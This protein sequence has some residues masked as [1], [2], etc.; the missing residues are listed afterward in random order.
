MYIYLNFYLF[1]LLKLLMKLFTQDYFHIKI[2]VKTLKI[3]KIKKK[4]YFLV[5]FLTLFIVAL[6]AA[7]ISILFTNRRVYFKL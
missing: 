2:C 3:A 7:G 1:T 6:D 5:V 4:N